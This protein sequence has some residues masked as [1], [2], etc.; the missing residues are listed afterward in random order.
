MKIL[1]R[2]KQSQQRQKTDNDVGGRQQSMSIFHE[3][4]TPKHQFEQIENDEDSGKAI[5]EPYRTAKG[6]DIGGKLRE[7]PLENL[8]GTKAENSASLID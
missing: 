7:Q 3:R 4:Y 8:C 2:Q 6:S 5:T 1:E